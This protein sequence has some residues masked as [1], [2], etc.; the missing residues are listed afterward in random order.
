MSITTSEIIIESLVSTIERLRAE[1]EI[2]LREAEDRVE[3]AERAEARLQ[4]QLESASWSQQ[5]DQERTR[6]V[7]EVLRHL[8]GDSGAAI[9]C[10]K[11][12]RGN[13]IGAI[14]SLREYRRAFGLDYDLRTSKLDVEAAIERI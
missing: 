12:Y 3:R 13:K 7:A 5:G 8:V 10:A 4:A 1:Q 14:K 11:A 2:I 9:A 6:S